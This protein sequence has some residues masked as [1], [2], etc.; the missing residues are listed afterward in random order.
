MLKPNKILAKQARKKG[1]KK[2]EKSLMEQKKEAE[3]ITSEKVGS[4]MESELQR[5]EKKIKIW[6]EKGVE[7]ENI[8]RFA[9]RVMKLIKELNI[10]VALI[11][12]IKPL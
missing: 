6:K 11:D 9:G 3:K 4:E 8:Q 7:K 2:S 5:L 10:I 1:D 12:C